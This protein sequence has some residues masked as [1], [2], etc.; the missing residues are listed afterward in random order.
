[1][2]TFEDPLTDTEWVDTGDPSGT[3][4]TWVVAIVGL[5]MLF[6]MISISR[7]TITPFFNGLFGEVPG[8]DTSEDPGLVVA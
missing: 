3:V 8:V 5:G 6:T 7:A 2:A 4:M 1:M